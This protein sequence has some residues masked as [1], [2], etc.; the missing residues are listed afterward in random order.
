MDVH[1]QLSRIDVLRV[2]AAIVAPAAECDVRTNLLRGAERVRIAE[3][4]GLRA[5][6]VARAGCHQDIGRAPVRRQE[7]ISIE[8]A[9]E[10]RVFR[11]ED[12]IDPADVLGF[13]A[14]RSGC[15]R[16]PCRMRFE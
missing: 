4:D 11:A 2:R 12:V 7:I 3:G 13:V 6:G 16:S 15:R 5:L 10:D 8:V 9:A 14:Q 1:A